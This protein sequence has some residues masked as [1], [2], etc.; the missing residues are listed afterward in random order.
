MHQV[1]QKMINKKEHL[2][3][4]KI[5]NQVIIKMHIYKINRI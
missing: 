1:L 5:K 2:K 4:V 3:L